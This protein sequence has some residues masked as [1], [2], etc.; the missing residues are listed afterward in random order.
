MRA[1]FSSSGQ[2]FFLSRIRPEKQLSIIS[3][4]FLMPHFIS[5]SYFFLNILKEILLKY[6]RMILFSPPYCFLNHADVPAEQTFL[7]VEGL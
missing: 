5:K 3:V 4:S 2:R 1:L 6:N 7:F